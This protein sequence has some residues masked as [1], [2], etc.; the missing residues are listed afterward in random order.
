M[1]YVKVPIADDL[2]LRVRVTDENLV[3]RFEECGR[4]FPV[5]LTDLIGSDEDGCPE[6]EGCE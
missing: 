2:E 6:C 5:R 3:A 4:E 1:F